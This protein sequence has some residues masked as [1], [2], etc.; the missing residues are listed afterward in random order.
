MSTLLTGCW[1]LLSFI[2]WCCLLWVFLVLVFMLQQCTV[3]HQASYSLTVFDEEA[4][5]GPKTVPCVT[6]A[7]PCGGICSVQVQCNIS[8]HP[9]VAVAH[10]LV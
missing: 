7:P 2:P 3:C 5:N 4:L 1:S 10:V 9:V 8:K 6:L